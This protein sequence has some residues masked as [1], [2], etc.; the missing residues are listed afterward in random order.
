MEF[1]LKISPNNGQYMLRVLPFDSEDQKEYFKGTVAISQYDGAIWANNSRIVIVTSRLWW[2]RKLKFYSY[3]T[4]FAVDHTSMNVEKIFDAKYKYSKTYTRDSVLHVLPNDTDNIMVTFA[5]NGKDWPGVHKLDIYTGATEEVSSGQ[6]Y[7]DDWYVDADGGVRYGQGWYKK[8]LYIVGRKSETSL[9]KPL[10]SEN[11]KD[12]HRFRFVSYDNEDAGSVIIRAT[13]DSDKA[14]FYKYNLTTGEIGENIYEHAKYDAGWIEK[15]KVNNKALAY[16]SRGHKIER[17]YLDDKYK[18]FI[19]TL[20][21][22]MPGMDIHIQDVTPDGRYALVF[23]NN[24]RY[25]GAF[26]RYDF[27]EKKLTGFGEINPRLN[28]NY[29]AASEAISYPS[30]DGTVI[31]AYLSLPLSAGDQENKKLPLI[32]MPHGGPWVR[33]DVD[34]DYWSQFLNSRG[35]AVLKPNFRGS[36]GFGSDFEKKGYGEWGRAV[37]EDIGSGV[38]YLV[39]QG[40][41]DKERVCIVGASF[42]GYAALMS[43]SQHPDKYKC[44]M[45][46]S[47]LTSTKKW[48]KELREDGGKDFYNRVVGSTG[49]KFFK[50]QDPIR[51]AKEITVPVLLIHGEDDNTVLIEHSQL[52]VKQM[53]K[54]KKKVTFIKIKDEGHNFHY[55]K[56]RNRLLKESEKFLKKHLG[57]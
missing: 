20:E 11:I 42:G 30:T 14:A 50:K 9:W 43:A 27:E 28:P 15:D 3:R 22:A 10:K 25:S 36:T 8:K 37:I 24:D 33:D 18:T 46:V 49:S 47:S 35:Y 6:K 16:V 19:R 26:Y 52:L 40:I 31:P 44:V 32:V 2:D 57:E 56:S 54:Y 48:A 39:E 13:H 51:R 41:V 38:D 7:I 12:T 4:L 5:E 1:Y 55:A 45:A 53:K 29:M 17:T 23:V 34:Y 21:K